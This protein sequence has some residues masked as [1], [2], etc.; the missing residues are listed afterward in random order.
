MDIAKKFLGSGYDV[1]GHY[2]N[3]QSV[4][5]KVFDLQRVPDE[6]KQCLH[7][8][9]A[10]CVSYDGNTVSEYQKKLLAKP[11]IGGTYQLFTGSVKAAFDSSHINTKESRF[12]TVELYQ[13]YHTCKLQTDDHQ[14]IYPDVLKDFDTK[15]GEWLID[16]YGGCVLMGFN[17]GG[18]WSD[19][20]TVTKLFSKS[21]PE[22]KSEMEGAYI[23][24]ISSEVDNTL[25]VRENNKE[26]IVVRKVCAIEGNPSHAPDNLVAWKKSVEKSLGL[27][28]FTK[29]GLVPIWKIFPKHE[30]KLK[31]ALYFENYVTN[32]Q[33]KVKERNL[34]E[35]MFVN[36]QKFG[37]IDF[38]DK[39]E[40]YEPPKDAQWK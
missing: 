39:I 15:D 36:G 25:S 33:I 32:N 18:R 19:N 3:S 35:V 17:I 22:V 21:T 29:D 14:Y 16:H 40:M 30:E 27:M 26:S 10:Y 2:A 13:C 1:C 9:F 7:N 11:K 34:L 6:C 12:I 20:L 23:A 8:K 31:R 24:F 5:K 38:A 37:S 28:D 4:K